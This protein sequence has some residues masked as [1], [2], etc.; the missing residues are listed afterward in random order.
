MFIMKV[1]IALF[2]FFKCIGVKPYLTYLLPIVQLN[3]LGCVRTKI[4]II[5]NSLTKIVLMIRVK[6]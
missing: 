1:L 6:I 5:Q 2:N 4:N 3:I